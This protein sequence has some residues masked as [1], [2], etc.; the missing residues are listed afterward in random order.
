LFRGIAAKG[1]GRQTN[2][3]GK[4][5]NENQTPTNEKTQKHNAGVSLGH[6]SQTQH[7]S[8]TISIT[9]RNV[10]CP[11]AAQLVGVPLEATAGRSPPALGERR[12][13]R[14]CR[15]QWRP[16]HD[17]PCSS[18]VAVFLFPSQTTAN[19]PTALTTINHHMEEP[20]TKTVSESKPAKNMGDAPTIA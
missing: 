17:R 10:P 2:Q 5:E 13:D 14:P 11:L 12:Q 4:L 19:Q 3:R 15:H 20:R 16:S 6:A 18:A 1:V 9:V 8:A 7:S